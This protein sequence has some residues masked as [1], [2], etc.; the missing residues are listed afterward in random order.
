MGA[1][2]LGT[3]LPAADIVLA[4]RKSE[5]DVIL[6]SLSSAPTPEVLDELSYI[7]RKV[8][9]AALWLGGAPELH[10]D[11]VTSGSRWLVLKDFFALER[12]TGGS[13]C[14]ILAAIRNSDERRSLLPPPENARRDFLYRRFI[15]PVWRFL[16]KGSRRKKSH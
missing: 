13:G 9:R 15:A 10:L 16:R 12:P 4:A 1:I 3:D 6:L 2:Y 14:T 8:P 5:A 7:A 11:Q